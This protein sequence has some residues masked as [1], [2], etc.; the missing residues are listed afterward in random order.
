VIAMT[1]PGP[2]REIVVEP[3]EVPA[4][5]PRREPEPTPEAKPVTIP[6]PEKAPA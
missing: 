4:P 6:E 5:H 2:D 3:L 1:L